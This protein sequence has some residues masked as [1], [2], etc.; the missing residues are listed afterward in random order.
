MNEELFAASTLFDQSG[1]FLLVSVNI[2]LG[3]KG[4]T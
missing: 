1:A 4:F 2:K 3:R